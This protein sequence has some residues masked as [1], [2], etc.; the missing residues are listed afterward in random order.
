M[1]NF[2]EKS[3]E[4]TPLYKIFLYMGK[5]SIFSK[6]NMPIGLIFRERHAFLCIIATLLSKI[7]HKKC[8]KGYKVTSASTKESAPIDETDLPLRIFIFVFKKAI[9]YMVHSLLYVICFPM[10]TSDNSDYFWT[11]ISYVQKTINSL[12]FTELFLNEAD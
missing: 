11:G 4:T 10:L 9:I 6:N 1:K 3:K 5:V 12:F 8:I 7:K 2:R